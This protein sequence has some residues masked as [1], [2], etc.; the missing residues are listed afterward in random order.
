MVWLRCLGCGAAALLAAWM[1]AG[2]NEPA[3]FGRARALRAAGDAAAW[4][5]RA[6]ARAPVNLLLGLESWRVA[7]DELLRAG[8]FSRLVAS[9]EAAL[10]LLACVSVLC[11]MAC[12][13]VA[14]SPVGLAVGLLAGA[15][16]VPA[17]GATQ[18]RRREETL[19][20]QVPDTFRSLAG[21]LGS[22]RTL[23]QAIS[24][25]GSQGSGPLAREFSRASLAVS[26]G[27]PATAAVEE[28]AQRTQAPGVALMVCALVV[29]A[30]TGAPLQGLFARSARLVEARFELERELKAK[31]AQVRLSSRIVSTLPICLVAALALLSPDFREGL[32]TPVGAGC[33]CVAAVLD[34]V[35]LLII[36]RLMRSV[37]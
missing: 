25:V 16:A 1:L 11:A 17:W 4:L 10:A 26:C 31:T 21:A 3:A 34:L 20:R 7:A 37:L 22:G 23:S 30:R 14:H 6:G 19:A 2:G 9:R 18:V 29:S 8:R 35:A 13:V 32:A 36:R 28:I 5:A 12:L 33:V 27:V 24:F 15:V